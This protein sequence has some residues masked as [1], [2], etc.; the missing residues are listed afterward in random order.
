MGWRSML[1]DVFRFAE[2]LD[3]ELHLEHPWS[4][5]KE[6]RNCQV[7]RLEE[8]ITSQRWQGSLVTARLQDEKFNTSGCF[9]WLTKWKFCSTH[10]TTIKVLF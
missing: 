1:K 7:Q 5:N 6:L 10:T 3:I 2:E 4:V 8:E 9:G